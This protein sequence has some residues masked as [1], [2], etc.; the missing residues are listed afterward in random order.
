M[1]EIARYLEQITVRFNPMV[2]IS[3][4]L[5]AVLLGLFIWLGGMGFRKILVA[6]LGVISGAVCGFFIMANG[7]LLAMILAVI[8]AVIA[9]IF[10]KLFTT[11]LAA[12]LAALLCFTVLAR[13]YIRAEKEAASI[14]RNEKQN[15]AEFSVQQSIKVA[16]ECMADFTDVT[17]QILLSMPKR[18]WAIMAGVA[19]V[20]FIAGFFQWRLTSTFCCSAL[21]VMLI[22]TGMILLLL[23]KGAAPVSWILGNQL[24]YLSVFAAM[25]VFGMTEQ[26]LLCPGIKRKPKRKKEADDNQKQPEEMPQGWRTS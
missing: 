9:V 17:K 12:V 24:F 10:N 4:G 13:P 21:G 8:F 20:V 22:F 25:T 1:F 5:A 26:F 7:V 3:P 19:A 14:S 15:K 6:I 2:L 23:Y 18:N 11:I 16:K